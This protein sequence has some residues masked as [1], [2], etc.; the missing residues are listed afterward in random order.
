MSQNRLYSKTHEW[1]R[2][3]DSPTIA[4]FTFNVDFLARSQ[5]L[6]ATYEDGVLRLAIRK[7]TD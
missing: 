3:E 5:R 4:V 6:V 2:V 7:Q 1:V